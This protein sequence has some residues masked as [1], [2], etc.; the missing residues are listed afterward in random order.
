MRFFFLRACAVAIASAAPNMVWAAD[1]AAVPGDEAP[2][3]DGV[4]NS[5]SLRPLPQGAAYVVKPWDN[6]ADNVE[7]S[8][9]IEDQLRTRGFTIGGATALILKFSTAESLGQLSSGRQRQ[10]IEFDA[11]AGTGGENDAQVLLNLFSSD[12]GGVFNE[13]RQQTKIPSTQ[14]LE[15]TIDRPDG[16]RLWQGEATAILTTQDRRQMS[17]LLVAP[18]LDSVGKTARSQPFGIK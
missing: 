2:R 14:S 15:M 13:G 11:T 8:H 17:R 5:S 1:G 12:K 10:V 18:L 7:L 16:Q 9:Y 6:S 3:P 4:L